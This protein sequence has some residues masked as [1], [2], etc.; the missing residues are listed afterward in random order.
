MYTHAARLFSANRGGKPMKQISARIMGIAGAILLVVAFILPATSSAGTAECLRRIDKVA[1][2]FAKKRARQV[3]HCATT[4]G[5]RSAAL[6]AALD[7][8][9]ARTVRRLIRD[10]AGADPA[11]LGLGSTCPD[12]TGQCTQTLDSSQAVADCVVCMIAE[13]IDPLVRRLRGSNSDDAQTC[14]GCAATDCEPDLF[15]ERRPGQCDD[16]TAVGICI[17]PP[18]ACPDVY[19]PVCGCDG[20]TYSNNCERRQARVGLRHPG[21]CVIRCDG[22]TGVPCPPGSVCDGLPGRCDS[23]SED[24]ICVPVPDVCPDREHPVCGCDGVTYRNNCERIKAGIRLLHFGPCQHECTVDANGQ[25]DC[26]PDAFC[27]QRPGV[28]GEPGSHGICLEK[29]TVCTA[30]W[31]PV[32]GCDGQTY[33]NDCDRMAAGVSKRHNGECERICGTVAG[34]PCNDGEL[35][36]L[37]PHTCDT[38]DLD[39]HCVPIPDAC[40]ELYEPVCGC[41][42]VTYPNDCE[43]VRAGAQLDHFGPC[44]R[45]CSSDADCGTGEVCV[46]MPGHCGDPTAPAACVAVPDQCPMLGLMPVCG[47]DGN[48]YDTVCEALL[49]GVAIDHEGSCEAPCTSNADC[50]AGS[51]CMTPPGHCDADGRCVPTPTDCPLMMPAFP[52]CSCDGTDYPSVCDALLAG[53]SIAHEGPCP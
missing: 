41:D 34:I 6:E 44:I 19:E 14:G 16:P 32:C 7:K 3:T 37:P 10:C 11:A 38:A 1:V 12:P 42:G 33:S 25:A 18:D 5:C 46:T 23:T 22:P 27:E 9:S 26:G 29:P 40:P 13:T 28:C 24:G 50:A 53:A 43:R 4:P 20:Q 49:A 45:P 8:I 21:P 48:T 51:T 31:D 2:A 39:G 35:C 36:E 17:E 52:V 15:C 47:C 30:E